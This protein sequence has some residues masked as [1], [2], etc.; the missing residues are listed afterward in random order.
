M[1]WG[2]IKYA[3]NS[4]LGTSGFLPLNDMLAAILGAQT[5]ELTEPGTYIVDVPLYVTKATITAC[6]GGGGGGNGALPSGAGGGGGGA[7][8]KNSVYT[9]TPGQ[10][11]TIKVGA[12][13]KGS[14]SQANGTLVNGYDGEATI[15]GSLVTLAGGS[16]GK[17]TYSTSTNNYYDGG[18]GGAAGGAGGGAGGAGGDGGRSSSYY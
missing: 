13:G 16:G 9:V 8:I 4:T 6:G 12:G 7:A 14:D 17:G 10:T 15:I 3:I 5:V 11:I 1:S 2:E 18:A